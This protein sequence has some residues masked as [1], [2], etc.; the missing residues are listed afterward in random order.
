[1]NLSKKCQYTLRAVLELGKRQGEGPVSASEIAA[2]QAIPLRFL[3][4]ILRE[5]RQAGYVESRRG[6]DGGYLATFTPEKLS[7]GEIIRFVDGTLDPT[8]CLAG[9]GADACALHGRCAFM[10]LWGRVKQ[11]VTDILDDA[12][13]AD[14]IEE[15][16]A[17]KRKSAADYRI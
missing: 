14:L 7:A 15:E 13:I 6:T 17:A 8:G 11:A 10:P 16:R 1:M 12:S 4:L 9:K 2:K 3:E 5:L